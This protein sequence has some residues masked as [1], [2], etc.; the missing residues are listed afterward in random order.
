MT[1]ESRPARILF[2]G[3]PDFA[4]P[5][6][7]ALIGSRHEVAAVLTR[8]DRPTGRGRKLRY[9]PVK[10]LATEHG[11]DVLQPQRLSGREIQERLA[12]LRT[13]LCV[14]VA[15]GL[16]LPQAILDIPRAGCINVHASLLPRWRGAA[17]VQAALLAGEAATGI[18]IMQMEASLDTGPVFA[19][20]A[21]PI[22]PE[23]TAD[24]LLARLA[25]LGAELLLETID[26]VLDGSAVA[27]AQDD[28]AATYAGRINKSDAVIDWSA[29]AARIDRQIRA[30]RSRPVAETLLDG[31]RMRCWAATP[32][33]GS[34]VAGVP[35]RIV[36]AGDDGIDV[37]TGDGILRLIE[38]QMPGRRRVA[39]NV[40]AHGHPIVGK[41]LGE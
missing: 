11:I 18:S 21:V 6:L 4:V 3:S 33:A 39:A 25:V 13:D 26:G 30:Y 10:R 20:R 16:L 19:A 29:P 38:V 35:G 15:Y 37:Q 27:R 31:H 2:A 5:C 1:T 17:P 12:A 8:P 34:A 41:T 24:A 22:A 36:G 14:V 23:D 40:F 9:G 32:V 28:A 7:A